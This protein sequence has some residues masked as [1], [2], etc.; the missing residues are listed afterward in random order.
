[1]SFDVAIVGGGPVGSSLALALS[2]G[3]FRVALIESQNPRPVSEEWDSRVYTLSPAS[4]GFLQRMGAWRRVDGKRTCT[5]Q[6]MRVFGDD[7]KSALGFSAYEAGLAELARVVESSRLQ[8]AF[9]EELA[10]RDGVIRYSPVRP[11]KL[12]VTPSFAELDLDNGVA[13]RTQLVIGADGSGSWVRAASGVGSDLTPYGQRG[14][15]ANFACE[16][17][18]QNTACQWFRPDGILAWLP[19]PRNLI[20]IVWSAKDVVAKQLLELPPRAFAESVADAGVRMLGR[21][22][23]ITAPAAFPLHR[24]RARRS[25]GPRVA[26]VGDAAHA[27]HPLAG[28]GINIGFADAATLSA[29]LCGFGAKRDAGD[30]LPLRRYERARAEAILV[31]DGTTRGLNALFDSPDSL[32]RSVRNRGLNLTDRLPVLKTLLTRRAVGPLAKSR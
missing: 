27:V 7:G 2:G 23:C 30:L 1:M 4:I 15:V 11:L 24:L 6:R 21:L 14:V 18:H 17:E 16:Q 22:T 8:Q 20:S 28:Q 25:V 12:T 10:K 26:L 9:S 29:I 31:M 5:V 32:I 19:L 13:I 3:G